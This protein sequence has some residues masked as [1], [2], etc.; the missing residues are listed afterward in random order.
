M[1]LIDPRPQIVTL[2]IPPNETHPEPQSANVTIFP[3]LAAAPNDGA[4]LT[5]VIVLMLLHQ[6]AQINALAQ[7]IGFLAVAVSEGQRVAPPDAAPPLQLAEAFAK[8][9]AE[10][11]HVE[12]HAIATMVVHNIASSTTFTATRSPGPE[13][14]GAPPSG[15]ALDD[16]KVH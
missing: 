11:R 3:S 4:R 13:D 10:P 1:P 14:G 2:A 12:R 9:N 15:S 5:S 16:L 7:Q 6:Q 8:A